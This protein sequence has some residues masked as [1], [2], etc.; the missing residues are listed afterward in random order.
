MKDVGFV[1]NHKNHF[2][3]GGSAVYSIEEAT[4]LAKD[5]VQDD[6]ENPT[7][8]VYEIRLIGTVRRRVEMDV[9]IKK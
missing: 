8:Y 1:V 2:G 9:D 7:A 6:D 5:S 3:P 4:R